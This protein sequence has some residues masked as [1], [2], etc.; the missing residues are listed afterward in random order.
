MFIYYVTSWVDDGKIQVLPDIYKYDGLM[1]FSGVNWNVVK[2]I[3]LII[4]QKIERREDE[5]G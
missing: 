5:Q 1:N 2:K 3:S 4:H